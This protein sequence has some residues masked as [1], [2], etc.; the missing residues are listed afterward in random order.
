MKPL[1][2]LV[3]SGRRSGLAWAGGLRWRWCCWVLPGWEER[4]PVVPPVVQPYLVAFS[5]LTWMEETL[6]FF[7]L[8]KG[9]PEASERV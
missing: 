1:R 8:P 3:L 5:T 2:V 6:V 9:T 4:L 7:H